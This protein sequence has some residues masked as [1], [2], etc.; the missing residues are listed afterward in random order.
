VSI[1]YAGAAT[2]FLVKIFLNHHKLKVEELFMKYQGYTG[3][4]LRVDLSRRQ[5][6][7]MPLAEKLAEDY[8]GGVG[9][10]AALINK[11]FLD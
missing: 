11:N 3:T 7:S 8:I 4:V 5:I 1:S 6:E 2:L 10:V 9:I